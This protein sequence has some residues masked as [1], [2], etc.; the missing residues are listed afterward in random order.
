LEAKTGAPQDGTDLSCADVRPAPKIQVFHEAGQRLELRDLGSHIELMFGKVPILTT[1]SLDTEFAFG[2]LAGQLKTNDAPRVLIGGLGFGCTLA[3]VLSTVGP[4]AEVIIVEKL[5]TVI[6]LVRGELSHLSPGVLLDPRVRLVQEDV[7]HVIAR[8]RGLDIILLDVD[9]GPN[10]ASFK[11]NAGLYGP[12]GLQRA[13]VSLRQGGS[14][15]VW[16][17]YPA[18]GFL[19][20]LRRAGFIA[21]IIPLR[22]RGKVRARAYVGRTK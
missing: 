11:S 14:Y 4:K 6:N 5:S 9:N 16:S 10:W 19:K 8:E 20:H 12:L 7:A 17:G 22:E 3:G 13:R 15:V 18:D 21:R 2:E 1:A